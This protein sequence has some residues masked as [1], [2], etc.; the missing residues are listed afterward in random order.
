MLIA[1]ESKNVN[2]FNKLSSD[3]YILIWLET[4]KQTACVLQCW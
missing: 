4:N 2:N 1:A 3:C